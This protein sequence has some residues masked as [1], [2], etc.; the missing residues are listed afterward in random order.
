MKH[1]GYGRGYRYDHA[2][3]GHAAGQ[4]YLP[5]ALRGAKWYAPA[6]AGFEKTLAERLA[7]W[8]KTKS[9]VTLTGSG[10]ATI[11]D[12]APPEGAG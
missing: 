5:E 9:D 4:E 11:L 3:G 12:T 2:E 7:W 10:R 8:E 1:L 6:E